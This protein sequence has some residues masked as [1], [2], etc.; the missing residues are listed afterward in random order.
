MKIKR[1]NIG[2]MIKSKVLDKKMSK[3]AFAKKL[4]IQ[5]QNIDKTV[6][7]KHSL[8]T[9]LLVDISE[10]LQHNFFQYYK[11]DEI[12]NTNDYTVPKEIKA[13]VTLQME[14]EIQEGS[15]NFS[16]NSKKQIDKILKE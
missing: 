11:S 16:F 6:F 12:C 9:D 2:E 3:A 4:N 10:V 1:V 7:G 13:T 15:I 5:R 8:E 14:E